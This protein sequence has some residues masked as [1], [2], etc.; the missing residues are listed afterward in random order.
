MYYTRSLSAPAIQGQV[1]YDRRYAMRDFDFTHLL[2]YRNVPIVRSVAKKE[3]VESEFGPDDN[4]LKLSRLKGDK[5]LFDLAAAVVTQLHYRSHVKS[6]DMLRPVDEFFHQSIVEEGYSL[7]ARPDELRQHIGEPIEI[8]IPGAQTHAIWKDRVDAGIRMLCDLPFPASEVHI[9]FTGRCPEGGGRI[10]N[11]AGDMLLYFEENRKNIPEHIQVVTHREDTAQNTKDNITRSFAERDPP[12][13]DQ[14]HFF[15]I[16]SLFHLPRLAHEVSAVLEKHV[17][18][19]RQI[20]LVS[21]QKAM[22]EP[23]GS[24]HEATYMKSAMFEFFQ[25]LLNVRIKEIPPRP[26]YGL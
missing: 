7:C 25:Q 17:G 24:F 11:E 23:E 19:A 10:L 4:P 21:A 16:S 9:T 14:S 22:S 8:V 2:D 3:F 1:K 6:A 13:A 12:I 15:F 26:G 20:T 5:A 18:K